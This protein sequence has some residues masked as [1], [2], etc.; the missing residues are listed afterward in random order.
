M[1]LKDAIRIADAQRQTSQN[2]P[3]NRGSRRRRPDRLANALDLPAS[4]ELA[5]LTVRVPKRNRVHWLIE[6][7]RQNT[8]LDRRHCSGAQRAFW[9]AGREHRRLNCS[10]IAK[11]EIATENTENAQKKHREIVEINSFRLES[12]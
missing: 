10:R 1:S 5:S 9:R 11:G 2:S 8:T 6:A 12:R 7:K 3:C 4:G